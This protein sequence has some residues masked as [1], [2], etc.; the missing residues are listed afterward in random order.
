MRWAMLARA[1]VPVSRLANRTDA[2]IV[3]A[4]QSPASDRRELST[5]SNSS[6]QSSAASPACT[7]PYNSLTAAMNE[8]SSRSA[9]RVCSPQIESENNSCWFIEHPP[10]N[11]Q[12]ESEP[13]SS[14]SLH[15]MH[16]PV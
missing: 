13:G 14:H 12:L 3:A 15:L 4:R 2:A 9:T 16:G 10:L 1:L 5:R 8:D 11:Y 7:G 6:S